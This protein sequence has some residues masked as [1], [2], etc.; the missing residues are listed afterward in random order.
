MIHVPVFPSNAASIAEGEVMIAFLPPFFK[1]FITAF[2]FGAILPGAK[3]PSFRY[4]S[5]SSTL[6]V[7]RAFSS[8]FPNLR[9]TF[10]TTVQIKSK[11]ALIFEASREDA[12]SLSIT[13]SIPTITPSSLLYTGIPPPPTAITIKSLSASNSISNGNTSFRCSMFFV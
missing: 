10:S 6:I 12:K 4:F 2:I 7:S 8:G 11:S 13:A 3:C 9:N 1:Y 5:A